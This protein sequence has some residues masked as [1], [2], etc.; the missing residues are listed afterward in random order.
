MVIALTILT[1]C[2]VF[3]CAVWFGVSR[4]CPQPSEADLIEK[5]FG[6]GK[7][8]VN[9]RF[10]ERY[11][12]HPTK[13]RA[14]VC[15]VAEGKQHSL[16]A[17]VVDLSDDGARIK[18]SMPLQPNMSVVLEMPHYRLAGTA[19][20]RYCHKTTLA[21]RVGLSFKGGLFRMP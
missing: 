2:L 6:A 5:R 18:S 8:P 4:L 20:V 13:S 21:Y 12:P 14:A 3:G 16:E 10:M 11:R 17:K 7:R 1:G 19:K 15:W 9:E